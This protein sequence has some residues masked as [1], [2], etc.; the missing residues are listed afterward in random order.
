MAFEASIG[1]SGSL[2]LGE[3]K[4]LNIE[5]INA[6][7]AAFDPEDETTWVPKDIT[8][9]TLTFIVRNQQS[10]TGTALATKSGSVSGTYNASRSVNTQRA[11]VAIA[12]TDFISE[13]GGLIP[14]GTTYYSLNRTD[15]GAE[16]VLVFGEFIVQETTQA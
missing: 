3:D 16:T 9:F 13:S 2:M 7:L 15:A 11:V 12:D 14:P 4:T 6:D 1:G 5:V 10:A 8:G